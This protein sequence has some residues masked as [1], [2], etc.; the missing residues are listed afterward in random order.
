M[1]LTGEIKDRIK[2]IVEESGLSQRRFS[3][4][5]NYASNKIS[6]ILHNDKALSNQFVNL[7]E[8]HFGVN[9]KWLETGLG[10]PYIPAIQ[11]RDLEEQVLLKN[12]RLLDRSSKNVYN[13]V[14]KVLYDEMQKKS[15]NEADKKLVRPDELQKSEAK[16][17][18][19]RLKKDAVPGKEEHAPYHR[20][21]GEPP[22][23]AENSPSYGE[24]RP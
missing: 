1:E 6:E 4:K 3:A 16:E 8:K 21:F 7:L 9:P 23:V 17:A 13:K 22:K 10:S 18:L 24:E 20:D 15:Q 11:A 12:F 14:W 19:G 5:M 2:R